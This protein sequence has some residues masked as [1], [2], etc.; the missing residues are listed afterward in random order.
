MYFGFASVT[1]VKP[2]GSCSLRCLA[3]AIVRRELP[4]KTSDGME[5]RRFTL[6]LLESCSSFMKVTGV[7]RIF[8]VV[9]KD[10]SYQSYRKNLLEGDISH[11]IYRQ[12]LD[13]IILSS[14]N[15]N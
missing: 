6:S 2:K 3:Q 10:L 5:L 14:E 1:A 15:Y 4:G 8:C 12:S 11:C 7:S 9:V 13:T